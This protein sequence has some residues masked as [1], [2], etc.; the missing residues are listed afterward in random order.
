MNKFMKIAGIVAVLVT[1]VALVGATAVFAQGPVTPDNMPGAGQMQGHGSGV[2]LNLMAVDEA[3]MHAAIAD[4]LGLTPEAF[5]AALADG[6]TPYT[7][8]QELGIDFAD[9]QAA[10]DA[11][12]AAALEQAVSDGLI[13]QE[14]ADWMLGRQ[15]GHNGSMGGMTPGTGNMGQ[16]AGNMARGAGNSGYDGDCP[17]ATP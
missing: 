9:I 15:A 3:D 17:Y 11:V 2:G 12:H 6:Q 1:V 14:Q 16:G 7:L 5:E 13:T 4:A 8:A 10:M